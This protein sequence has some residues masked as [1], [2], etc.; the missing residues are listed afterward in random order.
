MKTHRISIARDFSPYPAGRVP[1]DGPFNGTTFRDEVL[2]PAFK[3]HGNV[4]VDFD[5]LFSCGSS[6]LEEAFGG[7]L[8]HGGKHDAAYWL[9]HLELVATEVPFFAES[10]RR[11][12]DRADV[13]R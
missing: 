4:A 8:R 3:K 12:I 5:G 7:L 1:E 2:L 6:F 13:R 9:S 10:A 11:Y